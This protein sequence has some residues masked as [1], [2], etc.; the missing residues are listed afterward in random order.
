MRKRLLYTQCRCLHKC[1]CVSVY[2]CMY[3]WIHAFTLVPMVTLCVAVSVMYVL[4]PVHLLIQYMFQFGNV[5][6]CPVNRV[7]RA[8]MI[9]RRLALTSEI[10]ENIHS[11]KAYGWEEVMET[12]IKNI[13]Q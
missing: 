9:S 13:R 12:I 10:V 6:L 1:A 5:K 3:A 8:G 11:V 4:L 2:A 7:K